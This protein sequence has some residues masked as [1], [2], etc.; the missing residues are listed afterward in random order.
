MVT[1]IYCDK[2]YEIIFINIKDKVICANTNKKILQF[3]S[4]PRFRR[5]QHKH[6]PKIDTRIVHTKIPRT[7]SFCTIRRSEKIQEYKQK[8]DKF[9]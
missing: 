4:N 9:F 8:L 1:N 3:T 2:L 6:A 7:I 5:P